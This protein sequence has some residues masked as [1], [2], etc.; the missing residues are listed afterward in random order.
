VYGCVGAI[1]LGHL[2]RI[3]LDLVL[4][5][6]TPHDEPNT[7]RRAALPSVIGKLLSDFISSI[8]SDASYLRWESAWAWIADPPA[9]GYRLL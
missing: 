9:S 1:P 5:G 4:A 3:G 7:G 6:L 8:K 2:S